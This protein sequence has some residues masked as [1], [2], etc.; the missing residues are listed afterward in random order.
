MTLDELKNK[1]L[2]GELS[3]MAVGHKLK[4]VADELD[5]IFPYE[6]STRAKFS[7]Y[8]NNG[9]G[10][11]SWCHVSNRF[12]TLITVKKGFRPFCGNQNSCECNRLAQQTRQESKTADEKK[13]TN[14]KRRATN[15][16]RYGHDFASQ[17][18]LVKQKAEQT[19]I[20]KY[21]AKAPTLNPAV[22]SKVQ[23][24]VQENWGV[25]WPQQNLSIREKT[26]QVFEDEYGGSCPAKNPEVVQKTKNTNL[27]KYGVIVPFLHPENVLKN[28]ISMRNKT[29]ESQIASRPDLRPLFSYDE[30]VNSAVDTEHTFQCLGCNNAVT[31]FVNGVSHLRC[32]VCYPR[33]E[34]WGETSIKKFLQA[35]GIDYSQWNRELIKPLE[36]DFFLPNH[37]LAI[38]FNGTWYHRYQKLG[39]KKYHQRKWQLCRDKGVRLIQIWEHELASKPEVIFDRLGYVLGLE[40]KSV[41]ARKCQIHPVSWATAKTFINQSHLQGHLSTKHAWGL[42]FENELLAVASF[43][44]PRF[45]TSS[46]YELARFCV[47]PGYSVPGGLGR[48]LAHAQKELGFESIVSYSN[49]N[50]G[51]GDGYNQVGFELSHI[52]HPNHWYFKSLQDVQTRWH[53]QKH[54]IKGKATGST[55]TEIAANMG[56]SKFY[57]AGNAVWT[58][59]Y[60]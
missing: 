44:K 5:A 4:L 41:G 17:H 48:L 40:R 60:N 52:S 43:V 49:L 38:E 34:T 22:L 8:V 15:R 39:D 27:E 23:S 14:H 1:F 21:G 28:H 55:A 24:T 16:S 2:L 53:F 57:D 50:W 37:N 7:A 30:F 20:E 59:R 54:R 19:C 25:S 56:Y 45:G 11:N 51:V 31:G 46:E 13:L 33:R 10:T 36:V 35:N 29:Y 26:R 12:R 58:K 42:S 47:L 32:F 3:D 18:E 6:G 9:D